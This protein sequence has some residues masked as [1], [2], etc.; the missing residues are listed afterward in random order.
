MLLRRVSIVPML[1][2]VREGT[3]LAC[4]V[5]AKNFVP[6]FGRLGRREPVAHPTTVYGWPVLYLGNVQS[7]VRGKG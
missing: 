2:K 5:E 7:A 6:Y 3:R 4:E 1:L